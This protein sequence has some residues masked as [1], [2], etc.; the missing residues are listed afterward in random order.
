MGIELTLRE[1]LLEQFGEWNQFIVHI[2]KLGESLW[3]QSIAEG[4]WTVREVVAHIARWDDYFFEEAIAK[5]AESEPLTVK[6]IDYDS[7][8]EIAKS[9]G[10]ST[11]IRRLAEHAVTIRG[12]IINVIEGLSIA[13]YEHAYVDADGHPFQFESYLKDFLWH[14]RHHMAQINRLI[15]LKLEE[16]SLNGW[17]ALQTIL[18]DGWLIRTADGYTKRSNSVQPLYGH[19]L[20]TE[21][22]IN[23]CETLYNGLQAPTVFKVTPF[24]RPAGLDGI[25]ADLNYKLVDPTSVKTV[26]LDNM[27]L[28]SYSDAE[29]ILETDLSELWL[30]A[31]AVFNRLTEEQKSATQTMLASSSVKKCYGL[32]YDNGIPVACGFASLE[33]GWVGLYDV[34]TD[35]QFRNKGYGE[36]LIRH[37]LSWAKREGATHGYLLVV[38]ANAPAN[39]LYDKLGFA[40]AYEYWYRVKAYQ[41]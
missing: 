21:L 14:D 2:E 10:L 6:H 31:V 33:Q 37:L 11:S 25:L 22:K 39:R 16:M 20:P 18:C 5:A 30:D 35:E 24:A 26:V 29:I 41:G 3:N 38:K 7:Y 13:E 15:H 27:E 1:Q 4:K 34:V 23:Q 28:P 40:H 12:R 8:N 36:K 19:S 17:P 32:L 9:Y